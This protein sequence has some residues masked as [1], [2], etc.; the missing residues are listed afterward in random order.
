[1]EPN[2]NADSSEP[3]DVEPPANVLLVHRS[4]D[5]RPEP[6]A[7]HGLRHVDG[8]TAA[9]A[10]TFSDEPP[11]WPYADDL[12]RFGVV[13]VG[14]VLGAGDGLPA[15]D[16]AFV[17]DPVEDPTDLAAIGI[18]LSRFCEHWSDDDDHRLVV[19][20][21]SLDSLL[22]HTD[23]ATVFQFAHVLATRLERVDAYA[24][25]HLDTSRVENRVVATFGTLFDEVVAEDGSPASIPEAT[26]DEVAT[27]LEEWDDGDDADD[28]SEF[29]FG[30]TTGALDDLDR[31]IDVAIE[32]DP[33]S[34]TDV[35]P[36]AG[37]SP[38]SLTE[39]TDEDIAETLDE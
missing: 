14:D 13:A 37:E 2:A 15:Y 39:A 1:M 34:E 3:L 35:D 11:E 26:D 12:E 17:V 5:P 10:V 24:H 8:P 28:G 16:R 30:V 25:F 18:A 27:V 22:V 33:A 23:P 6:T 21:D 29:V 32:S 20:F 19:C 38:D 31:Q 9:V 36:E 7:C 4:A